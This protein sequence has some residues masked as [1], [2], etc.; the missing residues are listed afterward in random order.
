MERGVTQGQAGSARRRRWAALLIASLITLVLLDGTSLDL[1]MA[2]WWG[3]PTGFSMRDHPVLDKVLYTEAK[4]MA[5]YLMLALTANIAWPQGAFADLRQRDRAWM[6]LNVVA[7]ALVV[8]SLKRWSDSACPW[9]LAEFGGDYALISHWDFSQSLPTMGHCFPG[10]HAVAGYAFFPV[11]FWLCAKR[12]N[13]ARV[14]FALT[15]F[16]GS[17][18]GVAQQMRGA[19]F[20]SHTLWSAWLCCAS[21]WLF[22]E[23][24]SKIDA[25]WLKRSGNV[26]RTTAN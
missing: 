18:L 15:L 3:Y 8:P 13:A 7:V 17:T 21:A 2:R 25:W 6:V 11:A 22:Y 1:T 16:A 12:P 20:M 26:Q 4:Q 5:L 14:V 19:H 10:G 24:S 9:D 23:I